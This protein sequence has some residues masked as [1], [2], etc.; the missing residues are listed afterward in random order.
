M[1]PAR[2]AHWSPARNASFAPAVIAS[3]YC[4]YCAAMFSACLHTRAGAGPGCW[5]RSVRV[6]ARRWVATAAGVAGGEQRAEYRLHQ[7]AAKVA[8]K[9]RGADAMPAR[10]TGTDPVS[11]CE[12]GV[13]RSRRRSRP[14]PSRAHDR[15][16]TA[17]PP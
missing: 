1:M 10:S 16:R 2:Y 11:E 12:A 14:T 13:R 3:A 6:G 5:P 4:G 15:V 7:G 9:V 17:F 8:L